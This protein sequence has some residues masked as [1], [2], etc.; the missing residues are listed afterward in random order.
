MT[1]R[2]YCEERTRGAGSSFYYAFLFLPP[3]QRRAMMALYAF[4]REVD[5][6]ADRIA[7]PEVAE[8]RLGFWRE[9]IARVFRGA[10]QHPVG[11]E[12]ARARERFAWDEELFREILD[13][14][15]MD[16]ARAPIRTDAELALYCYRVAGAVGLLSIEVFGYEHRRARDFAVKLGEALQLTNILRD[17]AEDAA[18]DRFYLPE[19]A[20]RR[21]GVREED[22]RAGDLHE[23]MRRLLAHYAARAADAYREA[24]ALLPDEDRTSLEP[25]L[26][27][28][29]IYHAQLRRFVRIGM[30]VWRGRAHIAPLTKLWIAWRTHRRLARGRLPRWDR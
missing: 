19:E 20:R 3:E 1:P 25:S 18:R 6:I 16:V 9:E 5:D 22:L 15:A 28:G 14:M 8:A 7:N 12:L 2:Q 10:P 4:C 21:F 26:L 27:M 30:D 11:H 23:G 17:L 13:G 24:L 29:A